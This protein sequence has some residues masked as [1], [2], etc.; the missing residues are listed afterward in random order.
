MAVGCYPISSS[1]DQDGTYGE[2]RIAPRNTEGKPVQFILAEENFD[3]FPGSLSLR[4]TAFEA[5]N[6]YVRIYMLPLFVECLTDGCPV[7]EYAPTEWRVPQGVEFAE[8][9]VTVRGDDE[10]GAFTTGFESV[11][12]FRLELLHDDQTYPAPQRN[13]PSSTWT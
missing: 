6:V 3:T 7:G 13:R 12:T 5:D 10:S 4:A 11:L 8:Q 2:G 9:R 1:C